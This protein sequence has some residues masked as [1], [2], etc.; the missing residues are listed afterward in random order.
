MADLQK[1]LG[2]LKT[3]EEQRREGTQAKGFGAQQGIDR[4]INDPTEQRT[5][6]RPPSPRQ[7]QTGPDPQGSQDPMAM[8]RASQKA[9]QPPVTPRTFNTPE[10]RDAAVGNLVQQ[11]DGG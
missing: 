6:G 11:M 10:E 4:P 1:L 9:Q 5:T 2:G 3:E 8:A 7:Q